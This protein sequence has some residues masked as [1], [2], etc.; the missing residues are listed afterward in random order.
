[1]E[2]IINPSCQRL[3]DAM[4]LGKF[5]YTGPRHFLHA[6]QVAQQQSPPLGAQAG[7]TFQGRVGARFA[8]ALAMSGDG[9]TMRLIA[10][11]LY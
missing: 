4:H 5:L 7:N 3:A 11:L 6:S 2:Y 9:E 10:D 8:T 1:M